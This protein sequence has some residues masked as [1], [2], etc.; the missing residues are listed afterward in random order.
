MLDIVVTNRHLCK[1]DFLYTIENALMHKPFALILREKDLPRDEYLALAGQVNSL[2]NAHDVIFFPHTHP[3]PDCPNLHLP[4]AMASADLAQNY[5]LSVSVHSVEEAQ[6]AALLGAKFVV[7]GH[8]FDTPCKPDLP[9]RGLEFLHAVC[10]AVDIPV[11]AI[12]GISVQHVQQ[13]RDAGAAGL[14]RMSYWM[15][16]SYGA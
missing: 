8:I 16:A 6:I 1:G 15:E 13:C 5:A 3:L 9:A 14:C 12:G 10:K 11:F 2:C 4:F 7:A